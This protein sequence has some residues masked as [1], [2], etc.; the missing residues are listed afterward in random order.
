[1][2]YLF[3]N[4]TILTSRFLQQSTINYKSTYV[5]VRFTIKQR[6]KDAHS[7]SFSLSPF[8]SPPLSVLMYFASRHQHSLFSMLKS[9][10]LWSFSW[11]IKQC[12]TFDF[13]RF[14]YSLLSLFLALPCSHLMQGTSSIVRQEDS[15]T[16]SSKSKAMWDV[17]G[18]AFL[19]IRFP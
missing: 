12:F 16:Y 10:D 17:S 19:W 6:A 2:H 18:S 11:M 1:M 8:P 14:I 5:R 9:K 7:L 4:N 15:R 13:C 3:M